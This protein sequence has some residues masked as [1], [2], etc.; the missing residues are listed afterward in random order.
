MKFPAKLHLLR[1]RMGRLAVVGGG[2]AAVNTL[3]LL[4]FA[5]SLLLPSLYTFLPLKFPTPSPKHLDLKIKFEKKKNFYTFY[6]SGWLGVDTGGACTVLLTCAIWPRT[7][8]GC[9]W[10][11]SVLNVCGTVTALN[12][13]MVKVLNC[14]CD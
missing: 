7:A 3:F 8:S 14:C 1:W 2:A 11:R 4:F 6:E 10:L 5:L 9:V 13:L 12:R